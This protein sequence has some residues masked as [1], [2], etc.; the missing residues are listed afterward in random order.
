MKSNLAAPAPSLA[1]TLEEAHN[2]AVRVEWKGETALNAAA[3]LAAPVDDEERDA[4][5][6]AQEFLGEVLGSGPVPATEVKSEAHT[7]GI[8]MRTL[9]RARKALGVKASRKGELGKR[10]GGTWLWGLPGIK[11]ASP[12][13]WQSKSDNDPDDSEDSAYSSQKRGSELRL[14]TGDGTRVG[15]DVGNLNRGAASGDTSSRRLTAEQVQRV[16]RLV[17]EGM[18][19]KLARREVLGSDLAGYGRE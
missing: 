6:E 9:D 16:R 5:T 2:G 1:F 15:R 4:L 17:A 19:P 12:E 13:T 14:P 10:G 7:A 18:S 11:V 8:S 3:L